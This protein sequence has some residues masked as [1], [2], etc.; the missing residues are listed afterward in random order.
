MVKSE[1]REDFSMG[2]K[3]ASRALQHNEDNDS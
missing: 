1:Q 3:L 2:L